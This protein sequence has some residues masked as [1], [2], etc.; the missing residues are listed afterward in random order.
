MVQLVLRS[1]P[2]G[3]SDVGD[4]IR[5][6]AGFYRCAGGGCSGSAVAVASGAAGIAVNGELFL[7]SRLPAACTGVYHLSTT[8]GASSAGIVRRSLNVSLQ[9]AA[10][11]GA[12]PCDR[13]SVARACVRH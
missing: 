3:L 1:Q 11:R 9:A 2:L 6:P 12:V 10:A 5:N 8:A 7:S 13:V 4:N